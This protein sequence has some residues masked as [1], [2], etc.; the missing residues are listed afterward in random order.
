ML[1]LLQKRLRSAGTNRNMIM[2]SLHP[3]SK[4]GENNFMLKKV[5]IVLG[6]ILAIFLVVAFTTGRASATA[7]EKVTICH[8]T[9]S[10]TNPYTQNVVSPNAIEGHF[11]NPG[12]PKAG[13][14]SDLLFE[15]EVDCP[16]PEVTPTPTDEPTPTPTEEVTP[17]PTVDVTPTATPS[18]TPTPVVITNT[19]T[20]TVTNEK[21][22][23]KE[24]VKEVV[25]PASAP[26]TGRG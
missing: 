10:E 15:G 9:G 22:V 19:V 20:N 14:E 3:K 17:T 6:I 1:D 25:V 7:E 12:T 24:V 8:A 18:A 2:I 11:D 13:H 5:L 21:V 4:G 26:A 16:E 23:E